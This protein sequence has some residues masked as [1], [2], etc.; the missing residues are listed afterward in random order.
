TEGGRVV[1]VAAGG[2]GGPAAVEHTGEHGAEGGGSHAIHMPLPS[3]FPLIAAAGFPVAGYGLI[4]GVP[5]VAIGLVISLVGFFGW[6]LE[7]SADGG[8]C[9]GARSLVQTTCGG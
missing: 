1:P 5:A 2:S 9:C 6:A 4:F 7:P 3:S 8:A